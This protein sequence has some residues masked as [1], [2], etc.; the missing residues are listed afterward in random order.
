MF[1]RFL[2]KPLQVLM[3]IWVNPAQSAPRGASLDAF[4]AAAQV[5]GTDTISLPILNHLILPALLTVK[6]L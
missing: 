1:Q 3:D 4:G 5:L 6:E 2:C